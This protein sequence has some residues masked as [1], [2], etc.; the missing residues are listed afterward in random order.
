MS[1]L[2]RAVGTVAVACSC[3]GAGPRRRLGSAAHGT[4]PRGDTV[5]SDPAPSWGW[6]RVFVDG[7]DGAAGTYPEQWHVMPSSNPAPQDG[8]GQLD[9]RPA[10]PGPHQPGLGPP[11]GHPGAGHRTAA[12]ARHGEQLRRLLGAAARRHR[13]ARARRDRE[14]RPAEDDGSPARLPPL[15]RREPRHRPGPP[16]RSPGCP[17]ELWSGRPALPRRARSP[18]RPTGC[19]TPTFTVGGDGVLFSASDYAGNQAYAMNLE[20][21]PPPRPRRRAPLPPQALQQ[22]RPARARRRRR[23]PP[24]HARRLGRDGRQVPVGTKSRVETPAPPPVEQGRSPCRNPVRFGSRKSSRNQA[25]NRPQAWPT[26]GGNDYNRTHDRDAGA[27]HREGRR[28]TSRPPTCS[29]SSGP[30]GSRGPAPPPTSSPR[31]PLGRPPP[32]RVHP[33]R[34]LLHRPGV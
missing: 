18:G 32:T 15:L 8:L 30:E 26:V 10:Q 17:P 3:P 11:A 9:G 20:P 33:L 14:L 34:R 12:D 24:A 2:A 5:E 7:F 29:R 22:G 23:H 4:L 28:T 1:F 27:G 13:P 19:T 31:R 25:S 6:E 16:A 21:R